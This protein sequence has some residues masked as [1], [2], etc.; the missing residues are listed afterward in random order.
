MNEEFLTD[1]YAIAAY[2]KNA[3]KKRVLSFGDKGHA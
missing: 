2:I 1:A 3:E